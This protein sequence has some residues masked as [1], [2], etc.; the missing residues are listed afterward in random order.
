MDAMTMILRGADPDAIQ[1]PEADG[2]PD[3]IITDYR[4]IKLAVVDIEVTD[5]T[6]F[7]ATEYTKRLN[8]FRKALDTEKKRVL[9][10]LKAA[11]LTAESPFKRLA[12]E[13]EKLDN[14]LRGKLLAYN[15]AKRAT[16]QARLEAEQKAQR[17]A[18]AEA[19]NQAILEG[20]LEDARKIA[21][22]EKYTSEQ[23]VIAPK[24]SVHAPQATASTV[25]RW[26]Y[27]LTNPAAVPREFCE[28]SAFLINKAVQNGVREIPG[29]RI[30]PE[31]SISIR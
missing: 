28:P 17:K 21:E 8:V 2:L 25:T 16:E 12:G 24:V 29:V 7:E 18:L 26:K 9:E 10:P 14:M 3:T 27:E 23:V 5:A 20:K 31:E 4:Q 6:V 19:T 11:V 30:W 22:A 15:Q 1:T 13:L